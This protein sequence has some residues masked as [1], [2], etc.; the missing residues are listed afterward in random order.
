VQAGKL[1]LSS[2]VNQMLMEVGVTWLCS[3]VREVRAGWSV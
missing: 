3:W 1:G 2:K